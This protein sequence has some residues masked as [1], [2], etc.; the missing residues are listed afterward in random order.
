MRSHPSDDPLITGAVLGVSLGNGT[1]SFNEAALLIGDD[2]TAGLGDL[3]S[4]LLIHRM[5]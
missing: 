3:G 2:S 5:H 1:G 4:S